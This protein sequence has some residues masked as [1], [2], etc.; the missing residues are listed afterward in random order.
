VP[1]RRHCPVCGQ[2]LPEPWVAAARGPWMPGCPNLWCSRAGRGFSVAFSVGVYDGAL[3]RA[4]GR[5]KYGGERRLAPAFATML[6]RF[7][8]SRPSWF[9]EF[10][11]I[12]GVPSYTGPRSRRG[13]D[14]VGAILEELDS[15][16]S[17]RWTVKPQL[18]AKT[19]ETPAMTGL[20]WGQRQAVARG[21]LRRALRPV[22]PPLAGA[23][24]LV[25]DDV[26]TEGS[27]LR[28]VASE[29]RRAGASD[30]AALVLARPAWAAARPFR[31]VGP[32]ARPPPQ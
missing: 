26:F 29:L 32:G 8:R 27:T 23:Q 16:L 11:L 1:T 21:P 12:T 19:G 14:P 10:A 24:V 2:P 25:F 30:V 6:A 20:S 17:T 31:R 7:L 15:M 9:E 28:E 13:W 4:I 18:V 3:K 5:Y 22:G